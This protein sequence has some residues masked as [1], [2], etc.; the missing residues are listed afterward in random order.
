MNSLPRKGNRAKAVASRANAAPTT[1][2]R[3]ANAQARSGR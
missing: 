3:L 1:V 2:L